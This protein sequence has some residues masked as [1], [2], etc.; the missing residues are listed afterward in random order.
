[1]SEAA[2]A[3]ALCDI[4]RQARLEL[5]FAARGGHTCLAQAY[6]E[7]P[8]RVGRCLP[9]GDGV[10]LIIASSAPGVFGG[11]GWQ[12][13]IHVER[14]ARVRLTSQSALQVHAAA[15][16][17]FATIASTYR[18]EAGGHLHC[19][20]DPLIPF[21]EARIDQR[22]QLDLAPGS[23]LFWSDALMSGREARC[24]RWQFAH[25]SHELRLTRAGVPAYI[26]RYTIDTDGRNPTRKWVADDV[27]YFGT[28]LVAGPHAD[29][30]SAAS[31]HSELAAVSG[32][33]AS[34]DYIDDQLVLVR[35]TASHGLPF[36]EARALAATRFATEGSGLKTY[37]LRTE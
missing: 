19:E 20:W 12:Q 5:T 36:H 26:E 37:G 31:L 16:A 10:H 23:T 35:L 17:A 22:I 18:V 25:L 30:E 14:G 27:C 9:R 24:E 4:G 11:D 21:P 2:D 34:A 1:V 3:R 8:Y 28:V 32:I 13:T 33:L 15:D 7:S 6:A 29:R